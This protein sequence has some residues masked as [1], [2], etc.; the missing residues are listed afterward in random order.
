MSVLKNKI[1]QSIGFDK[2]WQQQKQLVESQKILTGKLLALEHAKK[3]S[4]SSFEEVEFSVF[5]QVG[6]DGILQWLVKH[7]PFPEHAKSFVE[8]GV[9]N[10]TE[11]TT[12][13]LLVNNNWRGMVMDGSEQNVSYI[14][15]DMITWMYD[16]TPVCSFITA[17]NINTL[18]ET[19]GFSGEIGILHIDID[20]NDY[21]VWKAIT[22]ANPIMVIVEY[23]SAFGDE[24]AITV[25][26]QPDF[27]ASDAHYSRI[28]FGASVPA[29]EHLAKEKGYEL[30]GCNSNGN[31]AYFIRNDYAK[32]ISGKIENKSYVK[33]KFRQNRNEGGQLT[34]KSDHVMIK[35]FKHVNVYNVLT[36]SIEP[37]N[38]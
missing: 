19:H 7:I 11:A 5:S 4:I 6:D 33:T 16:L 1:K 10:Y 30:I 34:K 8:F 31:N 26:Y 9:E 24:R 18:L 17:E 25:P 12:R 36:N 3:E 14:R 29:F 20:G 35:T 38:A 22:V 27:V 28:V 32:Y 15:N 2:L 37:L 13:F 21:W 23:N